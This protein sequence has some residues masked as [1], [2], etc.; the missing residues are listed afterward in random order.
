M[1][2]YKQVLMRK[3]NLMEISWIPEQ[4]AKVGKFLKINDDNGW[5][6]KKVYNIVQTS[7]ENNKRSQD[8]KKTRIASDI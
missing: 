2:N 8:Y 7:E 3:L 1:N 6:V 5:E 4:F